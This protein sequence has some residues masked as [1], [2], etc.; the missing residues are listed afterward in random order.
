MQ[1]YES[2][3][4][5][6]SHTYLITSIIYRSIHDYLYGHKFNL[7]DLDM[8]TAKDFLFNDDYRVDWGDICI[9]PSDLFTSVGLDIQCIRAKINKAL[10]NPSYYKYGALYE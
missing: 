1:T 2:L 10:D 3:E 6:E 9:S 5:P 8:K 7:S 4:Y